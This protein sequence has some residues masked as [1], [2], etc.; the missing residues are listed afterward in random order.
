MTRTL[1]LSSFS[2]RSIQLTFDWVGD[3]VLGLGDEVQRVDDVVRVELLAVME[4]HALS[5]VELERLVVDLPPGRSELALVLAG[6]RIAIDERVPDVLADDHADA[7]VVEEGIDVLRRLVVSEL[8]ALIAL[9]GERGC[10]RGED[11]GE[12][13]AEELVPGGHIRDPSSSL[14][15]SSR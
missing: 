14:R 9:A 15:L 6:V 5:Q 2:A 8:D 12:S 7:D 13:E 1:Y 4:L 11:A 3:L 10:R